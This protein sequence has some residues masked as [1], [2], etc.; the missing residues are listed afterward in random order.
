MHTTKIFKI[1]QNIIKI[2]KGCRSRES[3]SDLFKYQTILPLQSH[4]VLPLILFVVNKNNSNSD[5]YN[6]N[7][8]QIITFSSLHQ[9]YLFIEKGSTQL[10]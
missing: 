9:I 8:R 2:I 5:V 4:S 6:I 3:C 7:T 10:A 1:Q